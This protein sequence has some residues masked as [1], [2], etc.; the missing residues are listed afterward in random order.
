MRYRGMVRAGIALIN[1]SSCTNDADPPPARSLLTARELLLL[2]HD[3]CGP[4]AIQD[5]RGYKLERAATI[6]TAFVASS[7]QAKQTQRGRVDSGSQWLCLFLRSNKKPLT[8]ATGH[9]MQFHVVQRELQNDSSPTNPRRPRHSVASCPVHPGDASPLESSYSR[10]RHQCRC[11]AM[12]MIH[13]QAM[14]GQ[15]IGLQ[16]V[17]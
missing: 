12:H 1:Q 14:I 5:D 8:I 11:L 7:R 2:F 3:V 15:P 13:P 4:T 9:E 10:Y 17:Q 16:Y 6:V